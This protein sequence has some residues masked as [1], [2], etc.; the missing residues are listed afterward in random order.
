M[1]TTSTPPLEITEQKLKETT[2]EQLPE[3]ALPS[4]NCIQM[5]LNYS[6][7][8]DIRKSRLVTEVEILKS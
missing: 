4:E 3:F 5:I 7:N 6:K 2:E 8:L 1:I